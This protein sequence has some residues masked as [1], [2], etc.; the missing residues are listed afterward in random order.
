M[1]FGFSNNLTCFF[2]NCLRD[3]RQFVSY[4]SQRSKEYLTCSGVPQGSNLGPLL[5]LL[6]IND[7]NTAIVHSDYLLYADDLKIFKSIRSTS[8]SLS[9]QKDLD[10]LW[11]WSL[12]NR[13]PFS[14]GKCHFLSFSRKLDPLRFSYNL[15]GNIL[16]K[17]KKT[18][19]LGILFS[20]KLDFNDHIIN[21]SVRS[22]K[23]LGFVMRTANQFTNSLAIRSLYDTL[24]R[25]ILEYGSIIW[26]PNTAK[27]SLLLEKIQK[28]S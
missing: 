24:V 19:D 4:N 6:F 2:R 27:Y 18:L 20:E 14:I 8:D 21:L 1:K 11:K 28:K 5:F 15:G 9:L 22:S 25:S 10:S 7:I 17:E 12:E 26:N 13:L 16:N 23:M 3:R